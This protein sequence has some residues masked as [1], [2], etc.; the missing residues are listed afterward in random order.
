MTKSNLLAMALLAF[1]LAACGSQTIPDPE[2]TDTTVEGSDDSGADTDAWGEDGL[3]EGE[4]VDWAGED[5][6]AMVIFFGFD[7]SEIRAEDQA[8]LEQHAT[9]LA[10]DSG[11]SVRLEGHADE[12]GSREYNIALSEQRAKS[13]FKTTYS[14]LTAK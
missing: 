1:F 6:L 2:P 8:T 3:G 9:M 5:Q 14:L 10:N 7:Q 11:A 13:V 4:D 12:R